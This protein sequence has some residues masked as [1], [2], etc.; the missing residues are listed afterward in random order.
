MINYS[1]NIILR[2]NIIIIVNCDLEHESVTFD[3]PASSSF[4]EYDEVAM[5]YEGTLC[6][7]SCLNGHLFLPHF[8]CQKEIKK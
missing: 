8:F 4:Q 3:G 5:V 1:W 2:L 6:Y 7:C